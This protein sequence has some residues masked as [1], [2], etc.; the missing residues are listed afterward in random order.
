MFEKG[1]GM[2]KALEILLNCRANGATKGGVVYEAV[3]IMRP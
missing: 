3:Q 2:N 1:M